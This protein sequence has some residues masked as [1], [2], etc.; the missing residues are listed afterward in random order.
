MTTSSSTTSSSNNYTPIESIQELVARAYI[1]YDLLSA[2]PLTEVEGLESDTEIGQQTQK[3]R[4]K[5]KDRKI[6]YCV[7]CDKYLSTSQIKVVDCY[8]EMDKQKDQ[9]DKRKIAICEGCLHDYY[10]ERK[11]TKLISVDQY[12]V[13]EDLIYNTVVTYFEHMLQQLNITSSDKTTEVSDMNEGKIDD[14]EGKNDIYKIIRDLF[15]KDKG[16]REFFNG[17]YLA[18]NPSCKKLFPIRFELRQR[19][20]QMKDVERDVDTNRGS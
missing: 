1:P 13:V 14:I 3:E 7:F 9:I 10:N 2:I 16:V 4:E 11:L 15:T 6:G 5:E 12:D 8:Y 20:E 17:D 18:I 19:Y